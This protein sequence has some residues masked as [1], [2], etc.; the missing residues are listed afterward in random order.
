MEETNNLPFCRVPF[1]DS[2]RSR[3]QFYLTVFAF[4][5]I[6]GLIR[7]FNHPVLPGA[8]YQFIGTFF[9]DIFRLIERDDMGCAIYC[10]GEFLFPFADI[11]FQPDKDIL[12][13]C[14]PLYCDRTETG[15]VNLWIHKSYPIKGLDTPE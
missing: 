10:L 14:F 8:D 9:I 12:F 6:P 15:A 4:E 2:F 13:I 11:P 3:E 7:Q 1:P 5:K